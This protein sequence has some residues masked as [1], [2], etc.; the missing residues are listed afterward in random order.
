MR[1]RQFRT[2]LDPLE[3]R[4]GKRATALFFLPAL[5]GEI[6]WT[7]AILTALGTT[8]GTVFGLET[9]TAIIMSP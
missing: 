5:T 4:F 9:A 1:R 7:G 8:F 2:M 3:M 6:F